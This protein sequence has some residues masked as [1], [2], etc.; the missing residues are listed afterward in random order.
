MWVS[1]LR[2][3]VDL[4]QLA[5]PRRQAGHWHRPRRGGARTGELCA[6]QCKFYDP[7]HTLQKDDI[8]S[9]FTASGKAGFTSRLIVSTTDKWSKDAEEALEGQQIPVSRLRV[10]DLDDSPVDWS[11]FSL[12]QPEDAERRR[13]SIFARTRPCLQKVAEGFA[14]GDRGKLIMACGTGK[15]FTALKIVEELVPGADPLLFLVPSISL[16]SQSLKEWSSDIGGAA[17]IFAVCSD[18]RVGKR[19]ERGHRLLRPGVTRHRRA[20]PKLL[21][22]M[23]ASLTKTPSPSS[24]RPTS[25]SPRSQRRRSLGLPS[26]T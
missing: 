20:P 1:R 2:Q 25:P 23:S 22:R 8:D 15:T 4:G 19:T 26:S 10:Q 21:E 17:T 6:I 18:V 16:L 9:F 12:A 7:T 14:S 5:W 13:R 24:S 3:R 11:Q